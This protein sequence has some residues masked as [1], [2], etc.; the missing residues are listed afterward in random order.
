MTIDEHKNDKY[1]VRCGT[2]LIE[3]SEGDLVALT[4]LGVELEVRHYK[5]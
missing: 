2:E 5:N 4:D 3:V 1:R